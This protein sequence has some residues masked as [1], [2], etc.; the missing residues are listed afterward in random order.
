MKTLDFFQRVLPHD[1]IYCISTI[2]KEGITKNSFLSSHADL[3]KAGIAL[4]SRVHV[5]HACASYI[6]PGEGRKKHNT[7]WVRSF[8]IDLD[9][10]PDPKERQK[11]KSYESFELAFHGLNKFLKDSGLPMPLVVFSGGGLHLYWPL[12]QDISEDVWHKYSTGLKKLIDVHGFKADS[13]LTGDSARVLRTPGT[14]NLKNGEAARVLNDVGPYKLSQFN[15]LLINAALKAP[16]ETKKVFGQDADIEKITAKCQQMAQFKAGVEQTGETWIACG[17]VLAQCYNG[18]EELWHKWSSLDDRYIHSEAQKKWEDSV[19]FNNAITCERFKQV[20]PEGCKGCQETCRSPVQLGKSE[21]TKEAQVSEEVPTDV[22]DILKTVKLPFP[23]KIDEKNR[24]C[25]ENKKNEEEEA[26]D[27]VVSP[28]PFFV[29][30]RTVS[31]LDVGHN[32]FIIKHYTPSDGWKVSEVSYQDFGTSP[33]ACLSKAGIFPIVDKLAVAYVKGCINELAGFK[34]MTDVHETFGW[35]GDKFLLGD[36]LYY[37]AGGKLAF[38]TVHLGSEARALAADLRPGGRHSKGSIQGWREAAQRLFAPGHE[39]QACTLLVAAGAP[40]LALMTDVEGGTIWSLF[41][42]IGGKGKTTATVAGATLW[43]GWEAVST[44]AADTI[45]ARMAKLGTL[46]HLP[47]AYDEMRRD[48]PGI[49]KQF[50]QSFTAGAERA[51]LNRT[52]N[53]SRMPKSWRTFLLTS[54]NTELTGAIAA[55]DGSQAMS[56]RVFEIHAGDLPLRKGEINSQLKAEF[57]SNCG[58]AGPII[59]GLILKHLDELKVSLKQKE[60][61]YMGLLHNSKMRFRAQLITVVDVVGKLISESG[62]LNFD[63]NYYVQWLMDQVSVTRDDQEEFDSTEYLARYLREMQHSILYTT[64]FVPGSA[65]KHVAEPR[66]GRVAIRVETDTYHIIIPRKDL[67]LWIQSKDQS[68][69]AFMKDVQAKGILHQKGTKRT[70]TAGT[71]LISALE[72][73]LIF[74]GDHELLSG[75]QKVVPLAAVLPEEA[76]KIERQNIAKLVSTNP[77]PPTTQGHS[78]LSPH[79]LSVL[80][81]LF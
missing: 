30:D 52:A 54:A 12:D 22:K 14:V 65:K 20:N 39:W 64:E 60:A 2:T 36:R 29:Q 71:N 24:L 28:Y 31:E 74:R 48:N 68:M 73:V 53:M 17:R 16:A 58:H 76:K 25:C 38:E 32:A 19:N 6:D 62:L 79:Q 50:V 26:K 3:E 1:G 57:M 69:K 15:I 63:H 47:L 11:N 80:R 10:R 66:S 56:D 49:A 51:R 70:L 27:I 44:N 61:D 45:N 5:Y 13:G 18:T 33:N 34:K 72:Y 67:E 75:V 55:D 23:F 35:K 21:R 42:S 41:D 81:G 43:G 37:F 77:V 46:C 4:S 40:L 78:E 9:I 8:W 59:I 7:K